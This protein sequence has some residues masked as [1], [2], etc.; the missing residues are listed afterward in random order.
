[1][2]MSTK[3]LKKVLFNFF[4]LKKEVWAD[5]LSVLF[6]WMCF[7]LHSNVTV[8]DGVALHGAEL[9]LAPALVHPVHTC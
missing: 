6:E 4:F 7:M 3:W 1:M 5:L 2:L 9:N 8:M